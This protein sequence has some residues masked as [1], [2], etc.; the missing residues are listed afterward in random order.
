MHWQLSSRSSVSLMRCRVSEKDYSYFNHQIPYNTCEKHTR[1]L[2]IEWLWG[3]PNLSIAIP[4]NKMLQTQ[5]TH[6]T[7][8][9]RHTVISPSSITMYIYIY[10][11]ITYTKTRTW[12]NP[13]LKNKKFNDLCVA[14]THNSQLSFQYEKASHIIIHFTHNLSSQL[15]IYHNT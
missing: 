7:A 13:S 8:Q 4:S 1:D 5:Q 14:V 12:S 15:I 10:T 3:G 9:T 6:N 2:S 11:Y